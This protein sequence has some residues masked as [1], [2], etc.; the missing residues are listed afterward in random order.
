MLTPTPLPISRPV[1]WP[2]RGYPDPG[3]EVKRQAERRRLS[4]PPTALHL[5]LQRTLGFIDQLI[6]W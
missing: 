4:V 5:S 3:A 1:S 2:L 6:P